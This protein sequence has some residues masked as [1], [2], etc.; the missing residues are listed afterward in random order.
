MESRIVEAYIGEYASGKSENAVNRALWLMKQGRS[1]TLV[2]LDIVE[3][4]YTLRPIKKKLEAMGLTVLAWE[5]RKTMGLGEAGSIIKPEFRWVL[6]RTGDLILDVGYGVEGAKTLN[7][8][9][10]A[11]ENQYLKIY[12]IVN[13]SRPMTS[14]PEDIV[15]YI[16][17]LGRVDGIVNN[18]HLGSDTDIDVI[19]NGAKIVDKASQILHIPVVFTTAEKKHQS[20]L[21]D[22]DCAGNPVFYIERFMPETFW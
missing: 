1:V 19:Q 5:S 18:T 15:D 12:A 6:K 3:P 7:L 2:D 22:V 11:Y 17:S 21:G 4:F 13:V 10:G 14:I 20:I 16:R 8:I 9:H